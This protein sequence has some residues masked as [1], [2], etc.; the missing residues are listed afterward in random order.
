MDATVMDSCCLFTLA[1][2]VDAKQGAVTGLGLMSEWEGGRGVARPVEMSFNSVC[3]C[4]RVCVYVCAPAHKVG[5]LA[6][7]WTAGVGA[8]VFV[9]GGVI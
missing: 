5:G 6:W 7:I 8:S 1:M 2:G 9:L 3:V 4:V